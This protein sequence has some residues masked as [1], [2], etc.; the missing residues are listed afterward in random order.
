MPGLFELILFA[1]AV[2]ALSTILTILLRYILRDRMYVIRT[3]GTVLIWT[4]GV[5]ILLANFGVQIE[6]LMLLIALAGVGLVLGLRSVIASWLVTELFLRAQKPF[7]IGDI[8]EVEE[9]F[10]R[11]I[12][13]NELVTVIATQEGNFLYYPNHRFM[14]VP[15]RI[16]GKEG[17]KIRLYLTVPQERLEEF[18]MRISEISFEVRGDL[19]ENESIDVFIKGVRKDDV[20]VEL[21]IPVRNP[22]KRDDIVSLVLEKLVGY[23]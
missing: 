7:K 6:V 10:G 21:V 3:I 19:I 20:L 8:I 22:N 23:F 5:I 12:N 18:K 4:V 9:T 11:I 15:F 16:V 17:V 13:M 2:V 14:E 1:G